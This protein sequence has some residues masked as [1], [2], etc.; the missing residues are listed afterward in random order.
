VAQGE[1]R[2]LRKVA[3]KM[4]VETRDWDQPDECL[5]EK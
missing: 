3:E 2:P 4:R 5:P 1:S